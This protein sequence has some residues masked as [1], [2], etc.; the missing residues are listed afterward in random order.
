MSDFNFRVDDEVVVNDKSFN[1]YWR[2]FTGIIKT[3]TQ[4]GCQVNIEGTIVS[5]RDYEIDLKRSFSESELQKVFNSVY[6]GNYSF[7]KQRFPMSALQ[8]KN[9]FGSVILEQLL[10]DRYDNICEAKTE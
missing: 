8:V 2:G 9:Q 7:N 10:L 5:F 3:K 6:R 1:K 4:Y